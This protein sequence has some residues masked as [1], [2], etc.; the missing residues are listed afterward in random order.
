MAQLE[1]ELRRLESEYRQF[2]AGTLKQP[3]AERRARVDLAFRKHDRAPRRN[4]AERF[5]F[6]TLQA[7]YAALRQLWE[8]TLRARD[9]GRGV[10]ESD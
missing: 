10:S 5:R 4:T 1:S 6:E 9:E 2:F 7:R 3:P 8:R